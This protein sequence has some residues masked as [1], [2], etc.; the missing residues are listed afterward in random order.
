MLKSESLTS[1]PLRLILGG[2]SV[3]RGSSGHRGGV[4]D[5]YS[6][7]FSRSND[8][9]SI[10]QRAGYGYTEQNTRFPSIFTYS[11]QCGSGDEH[12]RNQGWNSAVECSKTPLLLAGF[13]Y[14]FLERTMGANRPPFGDRAPC[15]GPQLDRTRHQRPM[16][17]KRMRT[18][19]KT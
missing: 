2:S 4:Q 15:T 7:R 5:R 6:T 8:I 3:G 10:E 16:A 19:Q 9:D 11:A 17:W 1:S 13:G 14:N 12:A 18:L